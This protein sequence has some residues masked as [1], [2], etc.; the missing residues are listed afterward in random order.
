MSKKAMFKKAIPSVFL[1]VFV[2]FSTLMLL[3]VIYNFD[4]KYT[5]ISENNQKYSTIP[6]KGTVDF[7]VNGW[8]L[9]PDMLLDP[10]DFSN[11]TIPEHYK[12][13]IGQ[14]PN[15][16][17]FHDD[18][19]PYGVST[20]R[21]FL[22]GNGISTLYLQ[23]PFCAMRL[24]VDGV[25]LE[26]NG[27]VV[28]Y[29]PHIKDR[30]VSFVVGE[31]TEL[32]IQ[33]ANYSHYYGG[34]WY[35]PMIGSADD[36]TRLVGSRLIM[37]GF[38]AFTAIALAIFCLSNWLGQK[39][40][41][42]ICFYFGML[43]LSFGIRV[44]YPFIRFLGIPLISVLYAIED[45]SALIGVYCT[46]C[47]A[48]LLLLNQKWNIVKTISKI[49]SLAMC[50]FTAIIP[51]LVL[52]MYPNFTGLYGQIISWY[53]L[54]MALFFVLVAL[55]GCL[56]RCSH[57]KLILIAV[58]INGVCML[59]GVTSLGVFEPMVGAWPEEYGVYCMVI[60]FVI[61]MMMRNKK[62]IADN[63]YLTENLQKE[64]DEKTK[65]LKLLLSE[66]GQLITE[67]S[68]D[69]K[70]PLSAFYSM[71]Q[72][73]QY[74]DN[75]I[76][77]STKLRM[78]ILENKCNVIAERLRVLQELTEES[79]VSINMDTIVLNR[80]LEDFYKINK[81]VVELDG[82][83]FVYHG[84]SIPCRIHGNEENISRV[85]ENLIYNAADFTPKKGKISLILE[86]HEHFATIMVVDTGCGISKEHLP[87][88]FNRYYSTRKNDGCQGLGLAIA[89]FI[90]LEHGGEIMVDST[91]N[92][93]TIFTINLPFV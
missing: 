77:N 67:L 10:S 15:L 65:H 41:D 63:L 7:L 12:T 83:D 20:Y 44:S 58:T 52:P 90:V 48:L 34:I 76:D 21:L 49:I 89:R 81:P 88:I 1:L 29:S 53:K 78:K 87:K 30:I 26:G 73:I 47:I 59:Y 8:E 91:L 82:P 23:E 51:L 66:R 16:S 84:S 69:M 93:G 22:S 61:L 4:N 43:A 28:E 32:I 25:E 85:L 75:T 36:I 17:A 72:R 62:I 71:S 70:S 5:V 50:I 68:H 56:S 6:Q 79:M 74:E 57:A 38:L 46:L 33:T 31:K 11:G 40:R 18:K 14:Y 45:F 92:E 35:P 19:N 9:Y 54:L 2:V 13:W 55:Y 37:Y 24:F 27:E 64:V 3:K 42:S 80:F 86:W 60:C 39:K